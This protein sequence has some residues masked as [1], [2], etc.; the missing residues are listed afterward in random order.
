MSE[1]K[2][3]ML[4]LHSFEWVMGN[5]EIPFRS[6]D[7]AVKNDVGLFSKSRTDMGSVIIDLSKVGDLSQ[8]VTQWLELEMCLNGH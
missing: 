5:M 6:L 8:A 2:V 7:L 4:L 3:V 1:L